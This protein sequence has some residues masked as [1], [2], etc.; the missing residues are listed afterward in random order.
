MIT[1]LLVLTLLC[2]FAL[3]VGLIRPNWVTRNSNSTRKEICGKIGLLFIIFSLC[4]G[5]AVNQSLE[6]KQHAISK[7][8]SMGSQV[9]VFNQKN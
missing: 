1:F 5:L 4:L 6:F 3:V 7:E 2:L 9:I 8:L